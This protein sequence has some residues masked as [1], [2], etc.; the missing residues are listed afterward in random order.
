M[1]NFQPQPP[2]QIQPQYSH[3]RWF[4]F[5]VEVALEIEVYLGT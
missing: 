4:K 3:R 5:E 1:D 2:S